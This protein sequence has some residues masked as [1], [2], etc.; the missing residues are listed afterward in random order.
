MA[1]ITISNPTNMGIPIRATDGDEMTLPPSCDTT[2]DEKFN[3]NLP[4]NVKVK[5]NNTVPVIT[6]PSEEEV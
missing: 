5:K 1:L 3:W 4:H 2:V 6:P